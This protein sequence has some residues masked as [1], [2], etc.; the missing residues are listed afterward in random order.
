MRQRFTPIL[1]LFLAFRLMMLATFLP[2][3]LT[4]FGDY[5]YYYSLARFSDDGHFPF[6]HY[7]SEHLPVFPFLSIA[8]YHL[9]RLVSSGSYEAYVYLFGGLMVAFDTGSL[10]LFLRLAH[11]LWGAEQALQLG[12]TYSLLFVPLIFCWWTF[13]GMTA[14]FILLALYLLLDGVLSLSL[15]SAL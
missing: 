1:V 14:F 12:W 11:R 6:I 9:A 15:F 7:W 4:Q 3:D 8:V 5:P 13:E 10:H 2:G